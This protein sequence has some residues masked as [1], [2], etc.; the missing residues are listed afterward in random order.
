MPRKALKGLSY[1]EYAE[2]RK[3]LG[4]SGCTKQSVHEAVKA[5][6]ITLLSDGSIDQDKADRLWRDRTDAR[7]VR[8]RRGT[9]QKGTTESGGSKPAA[10]R[11]AD[12]AGEVSP[13]T[14]LHEGRVSALADVT[15]PFEVLGL[16]KACL[17]MGFTAVQACAVAL[18]FSGRA[19]MAL[20]DVDCDDMDGRFTEPSPQDWR[21]ALGK[22]DLTEAESLCDSALLGRE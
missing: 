15:S 18:L 12:R 3:S 17:G 9:T 1:S 14:L 7:R 13:E 6:R 21:A 4:L 8:S 5:G 22:F 20:P 19:A 10:V 16:A 11:E 2:H